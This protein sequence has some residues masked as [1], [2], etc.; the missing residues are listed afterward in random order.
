M[1]YRLYRGEA[2][3]NLYVSAGPLNVTA[4]GG[5]DASS[6]STDASFASTDASFASTDASFASNASVADSLV[7]STRAK[8]VRSLC[9]VSGHW[10]FEGN[11]EQYNISMTTAFTFDVLC[12]SPA[13]VS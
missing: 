12:V 3:A 13:K 8:R 11:N 9:D 4:E 1:R 7:N 10:R 2:H 5:D 6:V